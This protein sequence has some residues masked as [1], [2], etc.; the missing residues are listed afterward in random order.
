MRTLGLPLT[1]VLVLAHATPLVANEAEKT[2]TIVAI[3]T[4]APRTALRVSTQVLRFEV[5]AGETEGTAS[6]DFSAG[7][8]VAPGAEVVLTVEPLRS[9][10]GPG[11]AGDVETVVGFSGEGAGTQSGTLR[12]T[13]AVAARWS[14]GGLREGR[15]VFTLRADAPGV[16]TVPVRFQLSIP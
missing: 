11:G 4:F 13:P 6:V 5:P 3:A 9:V 2:A 12:M 15:L 14:G 8:R 16:Y 10:E 7:A 1:A